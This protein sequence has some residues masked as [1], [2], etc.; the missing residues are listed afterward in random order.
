MV[1]KRKHVRQVEPKKDPAEKPKGPRTAVASLKRV[2]KTTT[3]RKTRSNQA[4]Q[5]LGQ[6]KSRPSRTGAAKR[7]S[8][9]RGTKATM[10]VRNRS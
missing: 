10:M 9:V 3:S 7:G 6:Q 8:K 5:T 4:S 2:R 1:N